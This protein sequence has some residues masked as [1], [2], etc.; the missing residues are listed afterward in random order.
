VTEPTIFF[1]IGGTL[2]SNPDIFEVVAARLTGKSNESSARDRYSRVFFDLIGSMRNDEVPFQTV[3]GTHQA[4][5]S[6]VSRHGY[7]DISGEA[8]EI[9]VDTYAR[10]SKLFPEVRNVLETLI[11][12][13]V[14]M[15][16]A[17]DNDYDILSV[18]R[19]KHGLDRY[20][21]D[22]CISEKA[23]AYKPALGFVNILKRHLPPSLVRCYFVGDTVFDIECAKRLGV[24]SVLVARQPVRDTQ[25]DFTI[26]SLAGLVNLLQLT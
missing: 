14:R 8:R 4:A 5:L 12:R 20:M 24:I 9:C 16:V 26:E 7:K 13:N 15:F 6:E 22:Y 23:K 11:K 3:V 10:K 17:S 18:E 25:A 1:D 19:A 2:L 21:L